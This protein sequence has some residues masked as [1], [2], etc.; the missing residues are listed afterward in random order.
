MNPARCC[1]CRGISMHESHLQGSLP[2]DYHASR[3]VLAAQFTSTYSSGRSAPGIGQII[4]HP[5]PYISESICVMCGRRPVPIHGVSHVY[6]RMSSS[7][8]AAGVS[9]PRSVKSSEMYSAGV[10]SH[11]GL[12]ATAPGG[13][14]GPC[15]GG[16]SG[17][18]TRWRAGRSRCESGY[19]RANLKL[20]AA[21]YLREG[22][23]QRH[24]RPPALRRDVQRLA[25][26]LGA[27]RDLVRADL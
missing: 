7:E 8:T 13:S 14:G 23:P 15:G 25:V 21:T 2:T 19:A 24:P 6:S 20:S 3:R 12:S 4:R 17:T 18:V 10:R 16:S 27:Q 1:D 11:D 5:V 26:R 9:T 22:G